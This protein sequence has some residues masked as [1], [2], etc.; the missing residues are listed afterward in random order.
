M[1]DW[2]VFCGAETSDGSIVC[3]KCQPYR[4]S[5]TEDKRRLLEQ[6][7]ADNKA[8]EKLHAACVELRETMLRG[9]EKVADAA[10]TAMR[11]ITRGGQ[12]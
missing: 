12:P 1:S 3:P 5:L 10:V 11:R 2:C 6:L 9:M 8:R 7:E 4:D